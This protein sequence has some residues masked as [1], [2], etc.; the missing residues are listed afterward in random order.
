MKVSKSNIFL[1]ISFQTQSHYYKY[2]Y[3][4]EITKDSLSPMF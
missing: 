4:I 1:S 2:I 3:L